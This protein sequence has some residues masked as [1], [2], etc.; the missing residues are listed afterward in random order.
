M[1]T[2]TRRM[3]VGA[4]LAL[5]TAAAI[6]PPA[7]AS[8]AR[9]GG[10]RAPAETQAALAPRERQRFD[11]GW[12][13]ALGH[14]TDPTKDFDFGFG[15]AD[16]SKTGI[17]KIA[18]SDFDDKAWRTVDLPHD[19]AVELPFVQDDKGE[20]DAQLR[21]HGYRPL[22]RRYPATSVG[23]Y[24][25]SFAVPKSDLGR[26]ITIE[27]DGAMRDV[28]VFVN[29]CFIG[30]NANGYAPFAFDLTDFLDYGGTNAI[31]IRVDASFGDGWFYEGAGLYRHVWLRK[32]DP[33]HFGAWETVV[34][35]TP[36]A[37]GATLDLSTIIENAG[38]VAADAALDW[39]I[40]DA[41]G[42]VVARATVPA[43]TIAPAGT[44][45]YRTSARVA[46]PAMW[47]LETPHLYTAVVKVIANGTLRDAE[48]VS[49]GIRTSRFDADRGF[50]LNDVPL[51]IQGTCNHQNHAGVGAAL[52]DRLQT[53]R[54]EVLK[55]M[56]CNA[57]RSS[58][59]MPTPEWVEAC[60]RMGVM[61][62]CET[63]QLSSNPSGMA[64]LELMVKRFRNSPSIIGW[65][66]GNEEYILQQ[67]DLAPQGARIAQ[68]MVDRCHALDPTRPVTAAVNWNNEAGVS[69][70]L[71]IIGFNY[72]PEFPE[73]FHKKYPKRPIYG[74]ETSSAI[75]TRGEYRTDAARHTMSS[76]DGVVGWGTTPEQWWSQYGAHDWLAGGFAWT[77]F[78]YRGEPTPY[79][80]PSNASQFGIVD[81][82]GFPKDYYYYYKAWWGKA[83]SL[84]LFPHWNWA[85]QEGKPVSVWVYSNLDEIE[86][87]LNG[88][89]LGPKPMP[90]LKHV[91]WQVP[92]TPGVIEAIGRRDGRI[93]LRQR[94]ETTGPGQRL[95]LTADRQTI[96]ADGCDVAMLTV[97]LLDARGRA[98]PTA[99]DAL[100]FRVSG[101]GKLI[102]VGNGNPN[103]LE[104]DTAP[105]RMLFN[106]LAQL[107]VQ[108]TGRPG[109]LTVE[110]FAADG[111]ALTPASIR[112]SAARSV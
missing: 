34:R 35:A 93:V 87:L 70:P 103:S 3:L 80:W 4:G 82:C 89:S 9:G 88:Q 15:Q 85:G 44:A 43:Q 18:K 77:G 13:F 112:L 72:H 64:E 14:G 27:F 21:S 29:G 86:L 96:A 67:G 73:P 25:R 106:G 50:F 54:L 74:S 58:H 90:R 46:N 71:D 65:S 107:I 23:W 76:Y 32:T 55:G 57:V 51:K 36:G 66:I 49:F 68:A 102:G 10:E 69:E 2:L 94:R 11:T 40:V 20:G 111:S 53:Y 110:A 30:R 22:G 97:D 109:A 5:P 24:R 62:L 79:S 100:R 78:D 38:R 47:S 6:L 31:A 1:T 42:T 81:L 52:P 45:T 92:Y 41:K 26:R 48:R 84:H 59:N 39:T 60:D 37:G 108:S 98:V 7:R 105:Q 91:E 19:W 99:N 17:I 83:P 56:G 33:V 104:S 12:R 63:R 101:A 75:A 95:R 16:F 28:L 61:L 8:E